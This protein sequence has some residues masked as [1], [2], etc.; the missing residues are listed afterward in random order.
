MIENPHVTDEVIPDLGI[1]LSASVRLYDITEELAD[2][3]DMMI[4]K[5]NVN[6][7]VVN[8]VGVDLYKDAKDKI[9]AIGLDAKSK[10]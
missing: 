1:Q 8:N 7:I 3:R 5:G 6:A 9:E 4:A 2:V 10:K